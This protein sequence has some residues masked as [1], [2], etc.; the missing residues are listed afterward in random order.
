[1]SAALSISEETGLEVL[2]AAED[3]A[4]AARPL[5]ARGAMA[6]MEGLQRL[7]RVFVDTPDGVLQ[8]LVNVAVELCG[9]DSAGISLVKDDATEEN[10]YHW[11]ATAGAYTAFLDAMLPRFPSACGVTM[12]RGRPQ[13]FRVTQRFFDILGVVADPVTD[14]LLLP[15]Q[16]GASSGT[17]FVMAHARKEAFD[18]QDLRV[19]Q[20]LADFA[21]MA[22]RHQRQQRVLMRTASAAAAAA[23]ADVLAHQIN[24]PLQGLTNQ[25]YVVAEGIETPDA[26][27]FAQSLTGNL[28]RLSTLVRKLLTLPTESL[29]R[30]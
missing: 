17:I 30:K 2:D 26:R 10:Y 14:G 8:E 24:N 23:M 7:A 28:S 13:I 19:M 4:F 21:A 11:V 25:V 1:M 3:A 22:V 15:W 29:E 12:E 6:D 20:L 16:A 27:M 9:A 5:R 18:P